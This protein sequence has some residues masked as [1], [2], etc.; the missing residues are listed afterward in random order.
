MQGIADG[1][2]VRQQQDRNTYIMLR[3]LYL[4]R[5]S[6]KEAPPTSAYFAAGNPARRGRRGVR[7]APVFTTCYERMPD[8]GHIKER[9]P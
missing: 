7:V 8:E 1:A 2:S 3:S 6:D 4:D 5:S 9:T